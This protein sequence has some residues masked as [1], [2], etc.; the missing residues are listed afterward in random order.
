[1]VCFETPISRPTSSARRPASNC[2]NAP[3]ISASLCFP[4]AMSPL[5]VPQNHIHF[6]ADCGVQVNLVDEPVHRVV[7]EG[8]TLSIRQGNARYGVIIGGGPGQMGRTSAAAG[9][10]AGAPRE[11]RI[12]RGEGW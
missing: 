8:I 11:H 3:I 4:F 7:R 6:P 10:A 9:G 5:L 2:F 12:R 1:M